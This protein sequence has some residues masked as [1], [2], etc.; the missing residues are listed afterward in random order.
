MLN[1]SQ[2]LSNTTDHGSVKEH[3]IT[4]SNV[5]TCLGLLWKGSNGK[6]CSLMLQSIIIFI[7]ILVIRLLAQG[8]LHARA[9]SKPVRQAKFRPKS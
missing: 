6:G 1:L 2:I 4:M 8:Q 3:N 5:L 7:L 9:L